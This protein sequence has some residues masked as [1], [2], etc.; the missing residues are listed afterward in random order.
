MNSNYYVPTTET[1]GI[2][3][4]P[5]E[6]QESSGMAAYISGPIVNLK[7]GEKKKVQRHNFLARMQNTRKPVLPVHTMAERLMFRTLISQ[8]R[9]FNPPNVSEPPWN[10]AAKVW[11]AS[12]DESDETSGLYY[13]VISLSK[14]SHMVVKLIASAFILSLVTNWKFITL[15]G[16]SHPIWKKL[17]HVPQVSETFGWWYPW[18]VAFSCC[19]TSPVSSG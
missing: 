13:K 1:L 6:I 9:E 4:I 14:N 5:Q 3:P 8:N 10:Q 2:L 19:S 16:G 17:L 7:T 18:L 15:S 12:V 11:N